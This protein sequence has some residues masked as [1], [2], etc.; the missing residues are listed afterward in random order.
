MGDIVILSQMMKN[1][2][3]VELQG[4]A[5]RPRV[6]LQECQAIDS[7]AT[8]SSLPADAIV[9]KVDAFRSPDSVFNGN[10]GECR[11]ADYVIV[12]AIKKRIIFIEIKRTKD[13]WNQIVKQLI[14]AQCFMKYCE[15]VG[16]AFWKD[17]N[18]LTGYECRFISIGHT[19]LSK[20]KTRI[21]K[22]TQLHNSP[23]KAMKIDWPKN[24]Q[25]NML[26]GL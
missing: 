3:L 2:A 12:S 15:E 21:N 11:R 22:Q 20:K 4:S 23:D 1:T 25:F 26:A 6:I 7:S 5:D 17:Q 18:F 13:G 24:I 16:K 19:S 10:N 9:I 14:G 8:I